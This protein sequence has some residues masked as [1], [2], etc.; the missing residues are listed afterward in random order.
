MVFYDQP[1]VEPLWKW[2]SEQ[3]DIPPSMLSL[4]V[5]VYEVDT[6]NDLDLG[7]DFEAWKNSPGGQQ[8]FECL[9]WKLSGQDAADLFP[10]SAPFSIAKGGSRH[11]FNVMATTAY[12]DFLQSK[13]KAKLLTKGD[14]SAKNGTAA[15]MAAVDQVVSFNT[16]VGEATS[17]N[18][19]DPKLRDKDDKIPPD[20]SF[21][22]FHDRLLQYRNSGKVGVYML[23]VP[24]IGTESGELNV[25]VETSDVN[26]ATPSGTPVIERRFFSSKL[27]VKDGQPIVL[28][29]IKKDSTVKSSSG[30]PWLRDIPYAGYLFGRE[31]SSKSTKD[32]VVILTPRFKFC[33]VSSAAPPEEAKEAI[34]LAKGEFDKIEVPCTCFCF[35]QYL[36]DQGW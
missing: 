7:F 8:L 4:N 23:A 27:E 30:I 11:A 28:S 33:P 24:V 15:E 29:G 14:I 9:C 12:L 20:A 25:A 19:A 13:G 35:D 36:L 26:G 34:A 5:A 10:G 18:I 22:V 31:V 16:S 17:V 32:I 21:T 2:G 6:Q 3:V 1:N